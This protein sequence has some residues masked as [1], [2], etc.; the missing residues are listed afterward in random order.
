[1]DANAHRP[2][3]FRLHVGYTLRLP[4][5][6]VT[7]RPRTV[8]VVRGDGDLGAR[9]LVGAVRD[10][11]GEVARAPRGDVELFNERAV[12]LCNSPTHTYKSQRS[13]MCNSPRS[14]GKR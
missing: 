6:Q 2:R 14:Y 1:M 10:A 4:Y 3:T 8:D 12:D 13:Y 9:R 7:L 5:A 11:H